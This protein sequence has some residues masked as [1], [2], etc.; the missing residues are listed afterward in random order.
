MNV[1]H[2]IEA[3][4]DTHHPRFLDLIRMALGIFLLLK[5]MAFMDNTAYLMDLIVNQNVVYVSY[6][7]LEAL[8]YYIVFAHMVGGIL[9]AIG[10]LTR[11]ACIVQ[12][13]ILLVAAFST[14]LLR[15]PINTMEWPSMI[16]L[17]LVVVF[18]IVG[19][20]PWSLDTF[21][22]RMNTEQ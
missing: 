9:I 18:T 12:I 5:G 17:A 20:G 22:S 1:V 19:N 2:K 4:G 15:D 10:A 16:A 8:V 13:P 7:F 14:S 11:L 21:L 6:G 3:W